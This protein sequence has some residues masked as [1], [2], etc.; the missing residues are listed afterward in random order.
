MWNGAKKLWPSVRTFIPWAMW[1][2]MPRQLIELAI[3]TAAR[4]VQNS[5]GQQNSTE[6]NRIQREE[7]N[8]EIRKKSQDCK[9]GVIIW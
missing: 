8:I 4:A 2:C 7:R 1:Y 6:S 5:S 9:L 3:C